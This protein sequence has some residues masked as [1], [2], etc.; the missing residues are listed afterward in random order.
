MGVVVLHLHHWH[1]QG[2]GEFAA[3]AAGPVAGVQVQGDALGPVL[4]QPQVE[5]Q[6]AAEFG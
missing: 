1:A 5:V 3:V 2:L 6:G 4:E